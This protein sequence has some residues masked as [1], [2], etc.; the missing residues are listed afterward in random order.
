M[1]KERKGEQPELDVYGM[2]QGTSGIREDQRAINLGV[3]Q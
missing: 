3:A 1:G 2:I